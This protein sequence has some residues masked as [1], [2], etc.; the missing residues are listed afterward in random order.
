ME[1]AHDNAYI[2]SFYYWDCIASHQLNVLKMWEYLKTILLDWI[3]GKKTLK[4]FT[5]N[6][7]CFWWEILALFD[8]IQDIIIKL[9]SHYYIRIGIWQCFLNFFSIYLLNTC[10]MF[11]FCAQLNRNWFLPEEA[12][13]KRAH[14]RKLI[15][16]IIEDQSQQLPKGESV[17]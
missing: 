1:L 13:L 12:S 15:C 7:K 3:M 11:F 14:I 10:W 17:D 2:A 6:D 16:E 9:R 8:C 4:L 5:S